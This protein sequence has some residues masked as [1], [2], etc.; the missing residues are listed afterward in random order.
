MYQT[1]FHWVHAAYVDRPGRKLTA[2]Q[3]E[4]AC[5]IDASVCAQVLADLLR[6]RVLVRTSDGGYVLLRRDTPADNAGAAAGATSEQAT[7]GQA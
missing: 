4:R 7:S 5:G 6:A 3:V 2:A 1:A